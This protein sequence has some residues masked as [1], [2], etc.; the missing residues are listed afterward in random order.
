M[1]RALLKGAVAQ[2]R[3]GVEAAGA[4]VAHAAEDATRAAAAGGR[5]VTRTARKDAA[6]VVHEVALCVQQLRDK[7]HPEE[8]AG[9]LPAPAAEGSV[10]IGEGAGR[11]S[12]GVL[13]A[14]PAGYT[15]APAAD[16]AAACSVC[17]EHRADTVAFPCA[18]LRLC[19]T[20]ALRLRKAEC[21]SCRAPIKQI[22]FAFH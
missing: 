19:H 10:L 16:D 3:D 18:H 4:A 17:L 22:A 13:S 21:P 1:A 14:P 11:A 5:K 12:V 2:L 9:S 7:L 8:K 15:P 6:H 20:C